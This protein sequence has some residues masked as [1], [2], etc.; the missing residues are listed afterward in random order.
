MALG[1]PQY[2]QKRYREPAELRRRFADRLRRL[3]NWDVVESNANFVLCDL[4][5]HG[6]TAA[7]IAALCQ[8]SNVFVRDV[9]NMGTA[10][11]HSL[12]IAVKTV[13][14]Q[15]LILAAL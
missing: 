10:L 12:R 14:E 2:Y 9:S 5:K 6:P 3:K 4:P 1:E 15:D 13:E 8:A 11:Q 7:A